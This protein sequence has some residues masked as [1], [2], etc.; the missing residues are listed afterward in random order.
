MSLVCF[1]D[2][3]AARR[4][5]RVVFGLASGT[6]MSP[7]IA[8]CLVIRY[9]FEHMHFLRP[10]WLAILARRAW[11]TAFGRS[12]WIC[13][14]ME[15]PMYD[16]FAKANRTA[17]LYIHSNPLSLKQTKFCLQIVDQ[18]DW[19]RGRCEVER[20]WLDGM[21]LR[22]ERGHVQGR[23]SLGVAS[24]QHPTSDCR[25]SLRRLAIQ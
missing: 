3:G 5:R 6:L 22:R 9:P 12:D 13:I 11:C 17:V 15:A 14:E 1:S 19:I 21:R 18:R 8:W 24:V 16:I 7:V 25:A 2:S 10:K 4:R 23:E 20:D